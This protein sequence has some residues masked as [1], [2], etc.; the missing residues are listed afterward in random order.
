MHT[1]NL[2]LKSI[3]AQKNTP[4]N[5]VVYLECKWISDIPEDGFYIRIFTMNHSM[6]FS[7]FKEFVHLMFL[8]I[9]ETRFASVIVMLQRLKTIK[10]GLLTLVISEQWSEYRE[11]DVQKEAFVKETILNDQ[12]WDKVD[13]ILRFTESVCDM[14]RS[15][16]IDE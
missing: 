7:M 6:R 16:D 4:S 5:K 3:C 11:D 12:W 9:S 13:Y 14:L 2:A 10:K 15:C 1:L 8:S